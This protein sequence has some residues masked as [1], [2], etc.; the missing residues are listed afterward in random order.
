MIELNLFSIAVIFVFIT[1]LSGFVDKIPKKVKEHWFGQILT[2]S[3]CQTF[4]ACLIY[5]AYTG[6]FDPIYGMV[7]CLFAFITMHIKDLLTSIHDAISIAL[8]WLSE[9][10][11]GRYM[12]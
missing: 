5:L 6:Q 10:I 11:N 8:Y 1:D 12:E 9:K 2:C 7:S 4:W 3:L